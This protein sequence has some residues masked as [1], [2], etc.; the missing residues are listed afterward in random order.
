[1]PPPF[2]P[3]LTSTVQVEDSG[4]VYRLVAARECQR[5]S[6]RRFLLS[7]YPKLHVCALISS[8]SPFVSATWNEPP[9]LR[10]SGSDAAACDVIYHMS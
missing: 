7:D 1:V 4:S 3:L 5:L 9:R 2:P 10:D 6:R 8:F